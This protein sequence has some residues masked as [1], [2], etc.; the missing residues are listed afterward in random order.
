MHDRPPVSKH[1]AGI[2]WFLTSGDLDLGSFRLKIG[3]P[4]TNR[5]L[6]NVHN[7]FDFYVFVFELRARTGQTDRQTDGCARLVLCPIGRPRN[8]SRPK[9]SYRLLARI[10]GTGDYGQCG[11]CPGPGYIYQQ[12]VFQTKYFDYFYISYLYR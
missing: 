11:D 4:L 7:N 9:N 2:V 10:S 12:A 1:D 5:A 8:M 6:G 3:T